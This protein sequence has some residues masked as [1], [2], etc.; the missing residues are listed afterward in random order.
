VDSQIDVTKLKLGCGEQEGVS[1]IMY[2]SAV[3]EI[4]K[5]CEVKEFDLC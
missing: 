5:T 1:K 4:G 3:E 2:G